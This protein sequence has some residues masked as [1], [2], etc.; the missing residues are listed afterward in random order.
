MSSF[1]LLSVHGAPFFP[2][3]PPL[4]SVGGLVQ[5]TMQ[6]GSCLRSGEGLLTQQ[7][8]GSTSDPGLSGSEV[9]R[10]KDN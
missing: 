4:P 2:T 9:L 3:R 1:H 6:M 5:P 7:V 8:G 10:C